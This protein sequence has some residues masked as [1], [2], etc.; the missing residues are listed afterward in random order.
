MIARLVNEMPKRNND[1][2]DKFAASVANIRRVR[3]RSFTLLP[4][5][6]TNPVGR[7]PKPHKAHQQHTRGNINKTKTILSPQGA[8]DK[9]KRRHRTRQKALDKKHS[10]MRPGLGPRALDR[11]FFSPSSCRVLAFPQALLDDRYHLNYN[12]YQ[13]AWPLNRSM[14]DPPNMWL[15]LICGCI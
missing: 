15:L 9:N 8:L 1:L 3:Q 14:I 10:T 12:S 5:L 4:L 7:A 2:Q 6:S 11:F 13:V